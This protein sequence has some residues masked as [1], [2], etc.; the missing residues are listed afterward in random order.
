MTRFRPRRDILPPAQGAL[1]SELGHVKDLGWVL[2]GG[3]AIALRLGHRASV[4]FDFFNDGPL[5]RSALTDPSPTLARAT[6][7]QDRSDT[8]TVLAGPAE[9]QAVKVSF[10]AGLRFGRVGSPELTDD[11]VLNVAS[12]DD[13]LAHKLKVVLQ[14]VEAK[15]YVDVM[16]L[17]DSGAPLDRALAA[18]RAMYSP[19]FQPSECLKALTFFDGGDLSSLTD[20]LKQGLV[21]AVRAVRDLPSVSV[22]ATRLGA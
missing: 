4:D 18:A 19:A 15:D 16:A 9:R 12:T 22:V 1:W 3:T 11:G 21:R 5:H 17:V 10:F 20:D 13:L 14:R 7:L 2:Y 6:V 8:L